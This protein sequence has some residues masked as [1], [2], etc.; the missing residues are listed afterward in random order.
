M[1]DKEIIRSSEDLEKEISEW[2]KYGPHTNYPWCTIPDAIEITARHFAEWGMTHKE[3]VSENL[4]EAARKVLQDKKSA[5]KFLKEAGIIDENGNL[6]KEYRCDE[7]ASKDLEE[8]SKDYQKKQYGYT[9]G[10][11]IMDTDCSSQQNIIDIDES[12]K[13]GAQWQKQ[14]DAGLIFNAKEDGFRRGKASVQLNMTESLRTEYEKGRH[15]MQEEMM[16]DAIDSKIEGTYYFHSDRAQDYGEIRDFARIAPIEG[17]YPR[18][19]KVKI[20]IVNED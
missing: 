8:A 7:P 12:F 2:M 9:V 3:P 6:A 18:G 16:K 14:K 20:L 5:I 1:T 15:D 10:N 13:A 11:N 4:E 17:K 19:Q